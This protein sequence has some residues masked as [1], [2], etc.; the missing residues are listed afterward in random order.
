MCLGFLLLKGD[1][2]DDDGTGGRSGVGGRGAWAES[3]GA[4]LHSEKA[5]YAGVLRGL[6]LESRAM[7]K[8]NQDIMQAVSS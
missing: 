3:R 5:C 2:V 4:S 1:L 8:I 6:A 7:Q